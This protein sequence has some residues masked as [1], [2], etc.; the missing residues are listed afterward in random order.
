MASDP[1]FGWDLTF[2]TVEKDVKRKSDI[3]I[4]FIHWNL[5]KRG[6][7]NIGVGDERTLSGDE[8][9]SEVL[10]TGW[11]DNENYTLRYLFDEKLYILHGLNTD[12]NLI[13]N[14]MRS[15]DLAVSNV[16]VKIEDTVKEMSGPIDKML[17][18]HK[19][20]MYN[21][22]RDLIDT[23]TER[24]TTTIHTQTGDG[25]SNRRPSDDPLRVPPRPMPGVNPDTRDL[26]ELPPANLPNIGRSDLDP[27]APGGGGMIFNPFGPRRDI[28][29]PGLGIPGG[30]PRGAVPPGARF[31]PFGPPGVGPLP[32]RRPPPPDADHLPPPGFNDN[33]FL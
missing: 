30:L 6:F 12:G 24:S 17:P 27:F 13:L 5:T 31:D 16:V 4:A 33:M 32:G 7:R 22:K 26:W 10:P 28:E 11:N 3:I 8:V 9:K 23:L 1:L 15:E 20:L 2:R 14:L 18:S 29:N 25:S 21:V 19:D